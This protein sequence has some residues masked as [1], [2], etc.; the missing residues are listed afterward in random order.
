MV[1]MAVRVS[2]DRGHGQAAAVH[3]RVPAGYVSTGVPVTVGIGSAPTL[4][5]W[6]VHAHHCRRDRPD[7]S[8][9]NDYLAF[10]ENPM[11]PTTHL[12][13]SWV[14][15][16]RLPE[17]RDRRLVT[18]AGVAPDLDGLSLLGGV[19]SYGTWHHVLGHGIVAALLVAGVTA[20][21]ARH[22]LRVA[23]LALLTFHLHLLCDF[24]GSGVSWGIVY[25]YPFSDRE[26]LSP[27]R[28]DL[29]SWQ[30]VAVTVAALLAAGRIA[31]VHGRTFVE[32]L[33]PARWDER[34]AETLRR[35]L[36][37]RT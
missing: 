14:V 15:A 27:V 7:V 9:V 18:W 26:Y 37:R 29:N 23:T 1:G 24:V 31:L 5:E 4:D 25:W 33:A 36:G 17:R 3:S 11:H 2:L 13:V 10:L 34:V 22:R 6:R 8:E 35:R 30:N 19:E 32:A 28:W 16:H 20:A 12:I 21:W